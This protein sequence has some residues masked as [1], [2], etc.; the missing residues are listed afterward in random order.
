M[1][2]RQLRDLERGTEITILK[3]TKYYYVQKNKQNEIPPPKPFCNHY[4]FRSYLILA[5]CMGSY[6]RIPVS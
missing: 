5:R 3:E 4:S 1:S 6:G 2:K